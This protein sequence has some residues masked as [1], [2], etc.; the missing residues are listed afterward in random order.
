M[1]IRLHLFPL[2]LLASCSGLLDPGG[3]DRVAGDISVTEPPIVLP[4]SV[5]RGVS[6]TATVTTFGSSSCIRPDGASVRIDG[7]TA[8]ITPYDRRAPRNS[9][10][11]ADLHPFPRP[12]ELRFDQA[13]EALIRVRGRSDVLYETRINVSP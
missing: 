6:F 3:W 7:L 1:R 4:G 11:T 9:A 5:R 2:A 8:E 12:V 10:C 13:G